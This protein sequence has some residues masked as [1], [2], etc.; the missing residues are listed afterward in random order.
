MAFYH[1]IRNTG[2]KK[3]PAKRCFHT[4]LPESG[5]YSMPKSFIC[6]FQE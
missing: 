1:K 3:T 6:S 4:V 2:D 5:V